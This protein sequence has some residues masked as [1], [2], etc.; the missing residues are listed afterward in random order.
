M[1]GAGAFLAA[2][3]LVV[4]GPVDASVDE[5]VVVDTGDVPVTAPL[6]AA[7]RG[8]AVSPHHVL[9]RQLRRAS[10]LARYHPQ[11]TMGLRR[12]GELFAPT[13]KHLRTV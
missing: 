4:P 8:E 12:V 2:A 3:V 13:G 11:R 6:R 5:V 10:A 1:H 9:V 7:L